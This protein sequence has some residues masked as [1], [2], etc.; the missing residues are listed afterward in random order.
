[1]K[2]IS[3]KQIITLTPN[4]CLDETVWLTQGQET[5]RTYQTGG[6]GLNVAR[7][8]A[9]L[10]SP[11]VAMAPLG[12][13]T[14][15]KILSLAKQ[16]NFDLLPL[17]CNGETRTITTRV[18]SETYHQTQFFSP[19]A[20]LTPRNIEQITQAV[21]AQLPNCAMLVLSGRLPEAALSAD[22]T[23]RRPI[24]ELYPALIQYARQAGV[25]VWL[26]CHGPG[27]WEAYIQ[28]P[29]Y[30]KPNFEELQELAQKICTFNNSS[31]LPQGT[32]K[33]FMQNFTTLLPSLQLPAQTHF[34]ITLGQEGLVYWHNNAG[35]FY[36]SIP[37]DNINPV[38]SGDSFT[39]G[40]LHGWL[41]GYDTTT[42]IAFG[43]A[44]GAANAATWKAAT[45]TKEQILAISPH[46]AQIL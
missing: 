32:E 39:A 24:L 19:G 33:E 37:V 18:D 16:E 31:P 3:E 38:G 28:S 9:A 34:F 7:V 21:R 27:F 11:V 17:D 26:D 42:C 29:N 4:P 36:P 22:C 23:S 45:I 10:G 2:R 8:L 46:L 13:T 6:K 44:A 14:G 25:P 15:Q 35:K 5:H 30:V 40:W 41:K 12:G 1:M 20:M 43:Q